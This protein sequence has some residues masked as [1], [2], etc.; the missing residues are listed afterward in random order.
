MEDSWTFDYPPK[1]VHVFVSESGN[2]ASYTERSVGV[3]NLVEES[4]V[5]YVFNYSEKTLRRAS[6]SVIPADGLIKWEYIPYKA[7]RVRHQDAESI[8]KMKLLTGGSGIYDG[9]VIN[10]D[11][12]RTFSEARARAK[13]EIDAYKNPVVTIT[14][15]T[16]KENVKTGELVHIIDPAR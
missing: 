16:E 6:A 13:A 4:S 11:S 8:S 15:E 9:A 12:I 14:F 10:D 2:P 1:D 5:D 3:E 7:I